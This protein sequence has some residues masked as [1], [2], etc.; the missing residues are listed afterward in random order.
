MTV[1]DPVC[2]MCLEWEEARA[3]QQVGDAVVYFCCPGCATRFD[4]DPER[5]LEP[6]ANRRSDVECPATPRR[7]P[8]LS[9]GIPSTV[10]FD[11]LPQIGALRLDAF[12]DRVAR[13]WV[14]A[15]GIRTECRVLSR[16]LL[17]RVLGWA[18]PHRISVRIAAEI[19]M[20]RSECDDL[21]VILE[22]LTDLPHAVAAAGREAGLCRSEIDRLR[23]AMVREVAEA[24]LWL[25]PSAIPVERPDALERT[26]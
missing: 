3:F 21:A 19:S 5:Y 11:R 22:Q 26:G 25:D 4:E 1:R 10:P 2:G 9:H 15:G 7:H 23:K 6:G 14:G 16:A 17:S 12:E 20:L 13:A 8:V 24:V 18:E